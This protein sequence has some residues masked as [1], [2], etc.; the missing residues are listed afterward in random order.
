MP[1][2][3][4][5][6]RDARGMPLL[7]CLAFVAVLAVLGAAAATAQPFGGTWL[8]YTGANGYVSVP[9]STALNP[10]SAFTFEAWVGISNNTTGEDCR[11]IA[12]KNYLAAWWI[13]Q[14]NVGGQPTLRSYLKGGGSARNGGI[15]PRGP[16]T[17]VA[18]TFDGTTRRHYINGELAASFAETGPLTTSTDA[19][20]IGSDVS[21]EHSPTGLIDE[22]RI[23]NVARTTQQLRDWIN[24]PITVQPGLVAV[25]NL[26]GLNDPVGGHNGGVFNPAAAFPF[27]SAVAPNCG[28]STVNALCLQT[29]FSIVTKW[30]TNPTPGTPTDGSGS[31]V[32]A[33]P[34][35][36]IFWFF[37][38]DNW[39]VM[40]KALNGCGLNSRYW[41]FSAATTNVFYRM[42]VTD[43]T[44]GLT[45]IYFNYPGPP[46][47]AVTDTDAF[48]TCP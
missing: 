38:S 21:W 24:K 32:V 9:H 16:I 41:V 8:Q 40:V 27:S 11:S 5:S 36:G 13:G 22:V 42:E 26:P 35:S 1:Y 33:G 28:S 12:G 6:T 7:R 2:A 15:I 18:V 10:T 17:H 39:E 23:W 4:A 46:A 45:K 19:L 20:R 25:W 47:P 37:S 14:C 3:S 29:R 43:V 30:R 48:A 31:V 44:H 34:N